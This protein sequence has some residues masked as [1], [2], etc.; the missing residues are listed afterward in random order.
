MIEFQLG[1][2]AISGGAPYLVH[3]VEKGC[4]LVETGGLDAQACSSVSAD[5]AAE[6]SDSVYA[7]FGLISHLKQRP[8]RLVWN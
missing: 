4:C 5:D 8:T 3:Y 2:S 7:S 1:T 6:I